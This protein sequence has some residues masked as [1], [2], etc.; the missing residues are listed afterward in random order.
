M[1]SPYNIELLEAKID[2]LEEQNKIMREALTEIAADVEWDRLKRDGRGTPYYEGKDD[3]EDWLPHG[4]LENPTLAKEAL[5]NCNSLL[6][7]EKEGK[8]S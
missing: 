3:K 6:D 5:T 4:Y 1:E 8:E 7:S 2:I